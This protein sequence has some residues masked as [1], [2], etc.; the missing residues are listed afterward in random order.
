[1]GTINDE[2]LRYLR[3]LG[4][5]GTVGDMLRGALLDNTTSTSTSIP[6]LWYSFLTAQGLSGTLPDMM[7]AYLAGKGYTGTPND[8][9]MGA[10][11]ND[12]V[13]GGVVPPSCDITLTS[14]DVAGFG[15]TAWPVIS[16]ATASIPST[17]AS[18]NYSVF[19]TPFASSPVVDWAGKRAIQM[20]ITDISADLTASALRFQCGRNSDFKHCH[21]TWNGTEWRLETFSDFNTL[22]G[23]L[24]TGVTDSAARVTWIVDGDTGD[25]SVVIGGVTIDKN[26]TPTNGS[27]SV[28]SALFAGG[29]QQ[30]F[31]SAF[32]NG[33][34]SKTVSIEYYP[35]GDDMSG[36]ADLT[37]K[38]WCG[39]DL[40]FTPAPSLSTMVAG[41]HSYMNGDYFTELLGY[42]PGFMGSF[43]ASP[44]DGLVPGALYLGRRDGIVMARTAEFSG[45]VSAELAGKSLYLD[46]VEYPITEVIYHSSG[47]KYTEAVIPTLPT[48]V[49]G[50]TYTVEFR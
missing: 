26:T 41:Y 1:M 31:N 16:G 50:V 33:A 14:E 49:E 42:A 19:T 8:M 24:S 11:Q 2:W 17:A 21:A 48:F 20:A 10:V 6:D 32:Y 43:Y 3:G 27:I 46:G 13:F 12:D 45:D 7:H 44:S 23:Y 30:C 29:A 15:L 9:W 39:N 28:M 4:Y 38:D 18:T 22:Q 37:I 47:S 35:S 25:I 34:A 5:T 40:P 36:I